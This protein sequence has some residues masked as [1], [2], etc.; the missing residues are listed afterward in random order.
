MAFVSECLASQDSNVSPDNFFLNLCL[1]LNRHSILYLS[2]Q[3]GQ[4]SSCFKKSTHT[5]N[6][7]KFDDYAS[8]VGCSPARC[9]T[10]WN[11]RFKRSRPNCKSCFT[12]FLWIY[13]HIITLTSV[14]KFSPGGVGFG[15]GLSSMQSS[16]SVEEFWQVRRL[17]L[18]DIMFPSFNP[19]ARY[20]QRL[21]TPR[22]TFPPPG[23]PQTVPPTFA[24]NRLTVHLCS[25][26]RRVQWNVVCYSWR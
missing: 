18:V 9:D 16:S 2:H 19:S 15:Y 21:W 22:T 8:I 25:I 24:Q 4:I 17:R 20:P 6:H 3:T 12:L 5:C 7:T 1:V 13:A 23:D 26:V 11:E 14:L 10:Q